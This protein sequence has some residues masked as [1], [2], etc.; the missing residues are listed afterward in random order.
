[1]D[2][3]KKYIKYKSKYTR[4]K[5]KGLSGGTINYN[6]YNN[7]N[8]C[9]TADSME[10][11][12]SIDDIM[13]QYNYSL[14]SILFKFDNKISRLIDIIK[15]N[16]SIKSTKCKIESLD[17][18]LGEVINQIDLEEYNKRRISGQ[19]IALYIQDIYNKIIDQI[20]LS[21]NAL[22]KDESKSKKKIHEHINYSFMG[23]DVVKAL[24]GMSEDLNKIA[25]CKIDSDIIK[26]PEVILRN[27]NYNKLANEVV[28]HMN[29]IREV[30]RYIF[31]RVHL[32]NRPEILF[33]ISDAKKKLP[34][35]T[36]NVIFK[37]AS[38]NSAEYDPINKQLNIFRKE[39]L[40]KLLFHELC[41]RENIE[42]YNVGY[43]DNKKKI[44]SKKWAVNKLGYDILNLDE[45]IVEVFSEFINI[46]VV[47]SL[48]HNDFN[49]L[50]KYELFFGLFQTAKIL[51]IAGFANNKE[52]VDSD[53]NKLL[54]T[55]TSTVEYHIFKTIC[56]LNF[57]KFYNLYTN[58]K[59]DELYNMIYDFSSS[60]VAY[61]NIIDRLI[62]SF[63]AMDKNKFLYKTGRMSIIE[64][65]IF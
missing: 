13:K 30:K 55:T 49:K 20:S 51:Y 27:I 65:S 43:D 6:N 45:T 24:K 64:R 25:I 3:Y 37:Q 36:D 12:Q 41:H 14:E 23:I 54:H 58:N 61:N 44:W 52:F 10:L 62:K 4:L 7:Y 59:M 18:L 21:G 16:T 47:T 33:I 9:L 5:R 2:Y 46:V 53:N 17:T 56:M 34:A 60:N 57:N 1:M 31:P 40:S 48:C 63:D 28:M 38:I 35:K 8:S 22:I 42:T 39:E 50:W 26:L 19:N 11:I 29:V 15:Q 32:R